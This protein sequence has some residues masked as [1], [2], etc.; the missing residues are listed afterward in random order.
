MNEFIRFYGWGVNMKFH[1]AIYTLALVA[2]DGLVLWLMGE[3]AIPILILLEMMLVS[4]GVAV[5]ESWIF[6]RD[7]SFEGRTMVRRTALWALVCNLGFAG[8]AAV[9]GW[10]RGVPLWAA[11]LLVVFL[12]WG[13]SAMWFA[14]HVALKRDT[15]QLN[16]KLRDYQSRSEDESV[17]S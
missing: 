15:E 1:M 7:R 3:R 12:E 9:L 13:L 14:M 6:P 10:F 5:L 8:G 2:T 4:F 17:P 16:R 11:V